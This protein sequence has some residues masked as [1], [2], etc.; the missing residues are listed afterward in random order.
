MAKTLQ[1]RRGTTAELAS[2]TG[3]EAELFVDTTKDTVVVMDG[4]TAGGTPLATEAFVLANAGGGSVGGDAVFDSALIGNVSIIANEIAGVDSYGNNDVLTLT[5]ETVNISPVVQLVTTEE[6]TFADFGAA[7]VIDGM[8]AGLTGKV[9][10]IT[11][12][13][14]MPIPN[15]MQTYLTSLVAGNTVFIQ[16]AMSGSGTWTLSSG[17]TYNGGMMAWVAPV[18][19]TS[20]LSSMGGTSYVTFTKASDL[21]QQA[22]YAF[23]ANGTLGVNQEFTIEVATSSTESATLNLSGQGSLEWFSYNSK[24]YFKIPSAF[25]AEAVNFKAGTVVNAFRDAAGKAEAVAFT[26]ATG[27]TLQSLGAGYGWTAETITVPTS[28]M[29]IWP[30]EVTYTSVTA[31]SSDYNF[32]TDG[33]LTT[34]SLIATDALIGDVSIIGNTIAGVDSYGLADTLIVD[35]DLQVNGNLTSPSDLTVAVGG[36]QVTYD[37]NTGTPD[38]ASWTDTPEI[39]FSSNIDTAVRAVVMALPIGSHIKF[40]NPMYGSFDIVTTSVAINDMFGAPKVSVSQGPASYGWGSF[41]FDIDNVTFEYTTPTASYG[42]GTDGA[43][44]LP[45][46]GTLAVPSNTSTVVSWAKINIGGQTYYTP[47]YQ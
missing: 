39:L 9:V 27:M 34:T 1:F 42:F 30:N 5:G 47:L 24:W 41:S 8:M 13:G 2:V 10:V 33:T 26:L 21:T 6:T 22:S 14:G 17:F 25:T 37:V 46:N 28:S 16:Q 31:A 36:G 32:G 35:G 7:S 12:P 11:G 38:T 40:T 18:V 3:A 20:E 4:S 45:N 19:E 44:Q 29:Q 23:A 43:L 15:D